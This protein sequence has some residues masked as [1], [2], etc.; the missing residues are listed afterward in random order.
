MEQKLRPEYNKYKMIVTYKYIGYNFLTLQDA[1]RLRDF[2]REKQHPNGDYPIIQWSQCIGV[3][4]YVDVETSLETN[5]LCF[6]KDE[7]IN[8]DKK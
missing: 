1:E 5:R 4:R 7:D 8:F 3:P 6:Y 2:Y